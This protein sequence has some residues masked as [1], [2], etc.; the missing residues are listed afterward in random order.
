MPPSH[1]SQI[2]LL[3]FNLGLAHSFL[4]LSPLVQILE[5]L[6]IINNRI[7]PCYKI[8][9]LCFSASIDMIQIKIM[10]IEHLRRVT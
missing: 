9:D 7:K 2:Q 3:P 4:K 1:I 10:N 8:Q 6:I 5:K